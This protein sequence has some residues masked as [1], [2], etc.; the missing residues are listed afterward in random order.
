MIKI[1]NKKGFTLV[2]F[3]IVIAILAVLAVLAMN[4]LSN[5]LSK[6]KERA[7]IAMAKEM[8]TAIMTYMTE[9]EDPNLSKIGIG[10]GDSVSDLLGKLKKDHKLDDPYTEKKSTYGPYLDSNNRYT[11]RADHIHSG[12]IVTIYQ[13]GG[14]D[15]EPNTDMSGGDL[16]VFDTGSGGSTTTAPTP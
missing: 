1:K 7:D 15:V 2:E 3:L 4:I 10:T 8:R 5:V 13:G 12:W 11:P 9:A 14:C 6:S 16:L